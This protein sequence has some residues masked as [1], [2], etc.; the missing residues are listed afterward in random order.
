MPSC[1]TIPPKKKQKHIN[2]NASQCWMNS[3]AFHNNNIFYLF[4][5]MER[6]FNPVSIKV[7]LCLIWEYFTAQIVCKHVTLSWV[8]ICYDFVI[9]WFHRAAQLTGVQKQPVLKLILFNKTQ[10]KS[11]VNEQNT[12]ITLFFIIMCAISL[13]NLNIHTKFINLNLFQYINKT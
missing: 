4:Y 6:A 3:S 10:K 2:I 1:K 5:S 7:S 13:L 8:L 12:K 9:Y 11:F